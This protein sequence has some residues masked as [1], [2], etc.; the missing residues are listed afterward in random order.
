MNTLLADEKT[1]ITDYGTEGAELLAA[2]FIDLNW[3]EFTA[4]AGTRGVV[5]HAGHAHWVR[6]HVLD[7]QRLTGPCETVAGQGGASCPAT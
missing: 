4:W 6:G 3:M 5:N 2:A 1:K 7:Q